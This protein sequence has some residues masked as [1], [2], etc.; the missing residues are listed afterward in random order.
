MNALCPRCAATLEERLEGVACP[1]CSFYA[2]MVAGEG[3]VDNAFCAICSFRT[4]G[5]ARAED[6]RLEC[7]GCRDAHPRSGRYHFDGGAAP[8]RNSR[9]DGNMWKGKGK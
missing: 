8:S 4:E 9:R 3:L 6:G 2:V 1:R 7:A 5:L